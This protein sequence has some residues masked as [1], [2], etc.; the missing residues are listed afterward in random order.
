MPLTLI[1]STLQSRSARQLVTG[2]VTR[3][4]NLF[5]SIG[6]DR[7]ESGNVL[8]RIFSP[9]SQAAGW[10]FGALSWVTIRVTDI[11][12]WLVGGVTRLSTFNWNASDDQLRALQRSQNITMA[13]IW[14]SV[15][16]QGLG[17]LA[18]I[19]VG[20][21]VGMLCPVIGGSALARYITSSVLDEATA[22]LTL[23]LR[24]ALVQTAETVG[25]NLLISGYMQYR[26]LL[27]SAPDRVLRSIYGEETA[28]FIKS[29]WGREG[30]PSMTFSGF[31]EERVESIDNDV[32][33]VFVENML[34]EGWDS[35]VESGF[36]IAYEL[37]NA[38][39][40]SRASQNASLGKER[41]VILTPDVRA[42]EKIVI[43]GKEELA[44]QAIADTMN[45]FSLIYNRDVGNIVG[46][47]EKEY[48][49]AQPLRRKA[50]F[51][52]RHR[53]SPPWK[54]EEGQIRDFSYA[55]PDLKTGLS[56]L[57]L[58]AAARP[59]IW[60]EY[61]ATANLDN[62]RQMAIY[63]ASPNE[64]ENALLR[65][66]ALSRAEI[67]TLNVSQEKIRHPSLRKRPTTIYP[68]YVHLLVRRPSTDPTDITDLNGNTSSE[69]RQRVLLWP[70][71]E[72]SDFVPFN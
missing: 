60:G 35:F 67:V 12:G 42:N 47:T 25:N 56:W 66:L 32:V 27:K 18:G 38:F 69:E 72:P 14:G 26:N 68:A 24:A 19:G 55:V 65:L 54:D 36:I 10:L 20:Y 51:V 49:K 44:K 70:D 41:S 2:G 57:E 43:S 62:G 46:L 39:S 31:I 7:D 64:A 3:Y 58:K 23:G 13:A 4:I 37:D 30:E 33:R 28:N 9:L 59:F 45:T 53:P 11:F 40:Q 5:P 21:G 48:L 17:W 6:G 50:H 71:T 8:T 1:K 52:F 22:E 63:G 15:T 61:R 16:G 29:S 34:E